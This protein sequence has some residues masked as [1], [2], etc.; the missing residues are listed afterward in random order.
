MRRPKAPDLDPARRRLRGAG[1]AVSDV[2]FVAGRAIARVGRSIGSG[3]ARFWG[4]LSTDARRRLV[5]ALG[6]AAAILLLLAVAVPNLPCQAPGGTACPPPDDAEELVPSDTLAYVHAN[7]DPESEQYDLAREAAR[8]IPLFAGQIA[9]RALALVPGA[10]RAPADFGTEILPW[11]GGEAAVAVVGT[12]GRAATQVELLEVGDTGGATEYAGSIAAGRPEGE[13]YRGVE[14]TIDQRGLATAQ[15]DGFLVIGQPVGV[16]A[17]IDVATG[18]EGATP[19]AADEAARSLREELPDDRLI[20]AYVSE[21]GVDALISGDRGTLGS[22]APVIAPG[23]SV[24]AAAALVASEGAFELA[25]RSSLDPERAQSSPGFFAAFP[26]FEPELPKIL[27]ERSL[28]YIG[29]GE[30]RATVS[31]LL[32][33]ASAQA[34]GIATGFERL[35]ARLRRK[36]RVD[37]QR[38]LLAALGSEAAF[39]LAP[40]SADDAALPYLELV[41]SGV[42]E[43]RARRALA[44]LQGPLA[45]AV[46]PGSDLQAPVYGEAEVE[47]VQTRSLRLSPTVEITSAVFAGL[48][49]IAT[50]PAA[51]GQLARGEGGLDRSQLY[52]R[53]TE[54]LGEDEQVSLLAFFD[55]GE[56]VAVGEQLGL[57]EDPI[58][59]TFAGEFRRLE[60]L[61]LAVDSS[62]ELLATDARLLLADPGAADPAAESINPPSD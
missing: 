22:L 19:L 11:F 45:A 60:A 51:I 6:A 38:E 5:A 8:S 39:A 23:A 58:Y 50:D 20:E 46:D 12:G 61:G 26:S 13:Q 62:D 52:E 9:A 16:R 21:D 32:A 3:L 43:E 55:L 54:D 40:R 25:V 14:L 33:Q 7:L 4:D 27:P 10:G 29:F 2:L 36:G 41:A 48:A 49:V 15:V 42:D 34:P 59:A 47:G 44:S 1:Y 30:P 53:A 18:A 37:L 56:L 57:A 31:A 24:G 35:F 28:A 17:V